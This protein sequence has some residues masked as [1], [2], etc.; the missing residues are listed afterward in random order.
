MWLESAECCLEE[1]ELVHLHCWP[2]RWG[3]VPSETPDRA[4][5]LDLAQ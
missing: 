5:G 4:W 1:A 3:L 2:L